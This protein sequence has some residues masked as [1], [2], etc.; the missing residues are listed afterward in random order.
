MEEAPIMLQIWAS[1]AAILTLAFA[2][3]TYWVD[4][5]LKKIRKNRI[6]S[7]LN[8]ELRTIYISVREDMLQYDEIVKVN[9]STPFRRKVHNFPTSKWI[10]NS[11]KLTDFF[12]NREEIGSFLSITNLLSLIEKVDERGLQRPNPEILNFFFE[13]R[14]FPLRD[15][16]I[17][18]TQYNSSFDLRIMPKEYEGNP[19]TQDFVQTYNNQKNLEEVICNIIKKYLPKYSFRTLPEQY[20]GD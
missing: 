15:C 16:L 7:N 5:I 8:T 2:V 13:K 20:F 6:V 4:I 9:Y 1:W 17:E 14:L 10:I 18:L 3:I 11:G 19:R 12:K